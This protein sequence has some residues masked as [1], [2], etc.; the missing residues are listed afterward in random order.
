M[1]YREVE[2]GVYQI[3]SFM[4]KSYALVN[5]EAIVLI[6]SG[7]L[8]AISS[9]DRLL[10]ELGR[11]W[12][13][14]KAILLTHGHLDHIHNVAEIKK[15]SGACVM[16]TRLDKDHFAQRYRYKGMSRIC[17]ILEFLG[18]L[19]FRFRSFSL[20]REIASGQSLELWE[21]LEVTGLPGHTLGHVGFYNKSQNILFSGD[22]HANFGL[23]VMRPWPWLNSCPRY[24]PSSYDKILSLKPGKIYANHSD[25]ASGEQQMNRFWK[26]FCRKRR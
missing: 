5:S 7:F 13:D 20:D 1:K 15:R 24:F 8:G 21:G 12:N 4:V 14:I 10:N 26:A 22:S 16:G 17:G 18:R 2:P 23:R 11:E 3:Q 19:L 9:V 6:D 25:R